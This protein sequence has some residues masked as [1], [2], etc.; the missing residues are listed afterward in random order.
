MTPDTNK[1][2]A[3]VNVRIPPALRR[4]LESLAA[5]TPGGFSDYVRFALEDHVRREKRRKKARAA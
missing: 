2:E 3:R 1:H 5:A 4:D